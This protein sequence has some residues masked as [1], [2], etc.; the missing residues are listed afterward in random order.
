M[1]VVL[2]GIGAGRRR[3]NVSQLQKQTPDS[4]D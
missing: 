4:T 2:A 3:V 1:I